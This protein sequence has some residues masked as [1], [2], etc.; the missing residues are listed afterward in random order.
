MMQ[1]IRYELAGTNNGMAIMWR[2]WHRRSIAEI[3]I[4]IKELMLSSQRTYC[5][6]IIQIRYTAFRFLARS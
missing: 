5:S 1:Q 3:K 6:V 4:I 2:G